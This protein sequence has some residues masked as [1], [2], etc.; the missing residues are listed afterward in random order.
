MGGW[1]GVRCCGWGEWL[2]CSVV[3]VVV[4][5]VCEGGARGGGIKVGGEGRG[6]GRAWGARKAV[7]ALGR[8]CG[9]SGGRLSPSLSDATQHQHPHHV[10]STPV[11]PPFHGPPGGGWGGER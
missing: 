7:W 6:G 8:W 11:P 2:G 5:C 9:M 10:F 1:G 4:V 3:C